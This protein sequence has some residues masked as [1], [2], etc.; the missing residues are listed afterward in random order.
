ME[1]VSPPD[2]FR[3]GPKSAGFEAEGATALETVAPKRTE[4][5]T[6]PRLKPILKPSSARSA[7]REKVMKKHPSFG[8]ALPEEIEFLK[9][10]PV[11]S[12]AAKKLREKISFRREWSKP[13]N[14]ERFKQTVADGPGRKH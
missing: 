9:T 14:L 5:Q 4:N 2:R 10:E 6:A 11:N 12:F 1:Q 8:Y 3:D 13:M 7:Q